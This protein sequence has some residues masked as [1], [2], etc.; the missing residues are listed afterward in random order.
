M[1]EF[2]PKQSRPSGDC[3]SDLE[4]AAYIDGVLGKEDA[5][6]VT[7]HLASCES[8]FEVYTEALHFQLAAAP[9]PPQGEIIPFPRKTL[10]L[11]PWA[12]VA[13]AA[14]LVLGLSGGAYR[15]LFAPP[16]ELVTAELA[17]RE[18]AAPL[19]KGPGLQKSFWEGPRSRGGGKGEEI[20][21]DPAAFQVGV[22]LIDLQV[23]LEA[24]DTVRVSDSIAFILHVLEPQSGL[25][26]LEEAYIGLKRKILAKGAP[27]PR[28][29]TGE[30]SE[31][32]Q[33]TRDYLQEHPL[34]FGQW[35]EAGRLAAIAQ[36]PSFFQ[37]GEHRSFLRKTIWRQR[38][39]IGDMTIDP[40][41]LQSLKDISAV[42]DDDDL[43]SADYAKLRQSFDQILKLYY[44][45]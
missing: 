11:P 43:S 24:N 13:A 26:P 15:T 37:R 6:R 1:Q 38:F 25:K 19:K 35:V 21:V 20:P 28:D 2:A 31:L 12:A 41:A 18:I 10:G 4:L 33:E 16:P 7:E 42:L 14:V 32:I 23:S 9:A 17:T 29:F 30:A 34:D 36:E 5:A 22:R 27:P 8:C 40:A 3:P 45:S 44:P 39:G